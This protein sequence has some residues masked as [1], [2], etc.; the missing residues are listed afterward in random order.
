MGSRHFFSFA[1]L[2]LCLSLLTFGFG[3]LASAQTGTRV[4]SN[5][6][7]AESE[8]ILSVLS[9]LERSARERNPNALAFFGASVPADAAPLEIRVHTT[10]IAV[11]PAGA[12]VR[13][14]YWV[15]VRRNPDAPTVL[16]SGA[17]ELW[18]TRDKT[19]A[20]A[21]SP[22]RF[23][24]PPDALPILE[25][26]AARELSGEDK[27]GAVLDLVALRMGGR[28]I[29][30]GR[31]QRW[32]GQL[33]SPDAER[34]APRVREFLN[35]EMAQ[36]PRGRAI[37]AHFFLQKG[38]SGWFG[39]G[40][41]PNYSRR[42]ASE[43]D[44]RAAAHRLAIS[45][46][47]YA[48]PTAHRD[49]GI[50]LSQINL[51]DEAADEFQKAE[52]LQPGVVG[53]TRLAEAEKNRE[54]DPASI[55]LRQLENE[56]NVGLGSEHPHYLISALTREQNAR[57]NV[58]GSLRLAL[59]YSRLA[60][61]DRAS[62]WERAAVEVAQHGGLS[63]RDAPWARLLRE[64]LAERRE[65]L[66]I[67]PTQILRSPLFTVRVWPDD[68]RRTLI[69]LGALEEARYTVY[70]DFG[71]PM[72]NTEVLGWSSQ[73]EFADYTTRFTAQGAS[74]FVAA[75]TLTKLVRTGGG[76]V[77]LGEEVNI[78]IDSRDNAGLFSTVAHEYGHVAVRQLSKGRDVPVW[79]NEGIASS[80]EGGYEFYR[81]RV[82][83]AADA[84]TL[85]SM[86]E[87]LEWNV[88]GRR[89][90]LAYSQANSLIDFVVAKWG[91]NSVLSI[92]RAIGND[93]PADE[94]FRSV[95]GI[96]QRELYNRWA[97]EGIL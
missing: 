8:T 11:A 68:L 39:V 71:I 5:A 30:L 73:R 17:H 1:R 95:L 89:A 64:H 85:L 58:I 27:E 77:V 88:D 52:L 24:A 2:L 42:I 48:S 72:G 67:K 45:T 20:F 7:A 33:V 63:P 61:E 92:L 66:A 46:A 40:M 35:S 21:L 26:V 41:A 91:K 14:N 69:L 70:A 84:G 43:D 3:Q 75:L 82:Q 4:T 9:G 83:Q 65:L 13:Q 60:D 16:S 55:V 6:T 36:A 57:P 76:P 94:A 54:R 97:R 96:S 78:W 79:F 38:R 56:K 81:E 31:S 93:V 29:A 90:F 12:L 47:S 87:L 15:A 10:H 28:W 74:E 22:R 51:W 49:F 59:E 53:A 50:A 25:A 62:Q 44:T 34:S 23:L 32:S 18:L 19:N 37:L 86:S 80:V